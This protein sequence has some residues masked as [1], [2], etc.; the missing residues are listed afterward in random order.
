MTHKE[1]VAFAIS[2]LTARGVGKGTLA[3]PLFQLAWKLCIPI[4]PPLFMNFYGVALLMGSFFGVFWGLLM[5][6]LFWSRTDLGTVGAVIAS[7][8]AGVLFGL[9]MASYYRRNARKLGLP[10]WHD[11]GTKG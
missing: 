3:P 4:P 10:S 2:D 9:W 7:A 8:A 1:K 5:W 6:F 11:Y